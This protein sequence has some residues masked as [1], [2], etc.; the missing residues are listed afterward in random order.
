MQLPVAPSDDAV[1]LRPLWGA[2]L[3]STRFARRA[4]WRFGN[5]QAVLACTERR[6][7]RWLTE[8]RTPADPVRIRFATGAWGSAY[9][10]S[11]GAAR[12]IDVFA[13]DGSP[14]AVLRLDRVDAAL[15]ELIW[16]L[17][18][19]APPAASAPPPAPA[20][21]RTRL[22][23]ALAVAETRGAFDALIR[24]AALPRA[25]ALALS[26]PDVARRLAAGSAGAALA[27]AAAAGLPL[28]LQLEN[29]GGAITWSPAGATLDAGDPAHVRA[30]DVCLDIAADAP[31]WAVMLAT[32]DVCGPALELCGSD[33]T[34]RLRIDIADHTPDDCA[35]WRR[36]CARLDAAQEER[37]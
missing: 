21:D 9:A 15:D 10:R 25:D 28:R 7:R 33:G 19:D 34:C 13:A 36:I 6:S 26:G 3:S 1:R 18:D 5:D 30:R 4:E 32:P 27:H 8:D 16:Q 37:G 11:A 17:I 29:A 24:E 20:V 2:V 31:V 14:V 35:A 12:E 23:D 22:A